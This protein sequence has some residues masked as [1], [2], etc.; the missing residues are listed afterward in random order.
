MSLMKDTVAGLLAEPCVTLLTRE[1]LL[2]R[3]SGALSNHETINV[4][5]GK[6]ERGGLFCARVF[7]PEDDDCCLCTK[8]HLAIHRGVTCEKC[9]VL[10]GPSSLRAERVGHFVLAAPIPHPLL[11]P[12]LSTLLSLGELSR[13][14]W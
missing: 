8:Y 7:G 4:R 11:L 2:H 9:G 1:T 3:S 13:P 14:L 6:P 5:T 10:V 12:Q